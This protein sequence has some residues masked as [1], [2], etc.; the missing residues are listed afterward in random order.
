MIV[1]ISA[2]FGVE[3]LDDLAE[4]GA[5]MFEHMG[6]HMI[7]PDQ[8]T[9]LLYLCGKMTVAEMPGELGEMAPIAPADLQQ[10]L[11]FRTDDDDPAI[12]EHQ[13]VAVTEMGCLG[14]V[15]NEGSSLVAGHRDPAAVAAVIVKTN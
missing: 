4:G 14:K 12:V 6:D 2:G 7:A 1:A 3:G 9:V 10:L 8:D 15:E 11:G 5:L 13:S